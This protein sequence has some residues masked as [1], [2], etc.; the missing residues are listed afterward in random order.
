MPSDIRIGGTMST[1]S[2]DIHFNGKI[3]DIRFYDRALS[4]AE[5]KALYNL[6]N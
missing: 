3:D 2:G 6:G 5:I 1:F 4:Q